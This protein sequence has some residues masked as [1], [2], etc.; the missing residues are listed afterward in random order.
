MD[1][2]EWIILR[3]TDALEEGEIFKILS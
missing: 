1:P 2:N 3:S